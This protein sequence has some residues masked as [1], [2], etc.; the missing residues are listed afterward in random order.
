MLV[1]GK[2]NNVAQEYRDLLASVVM[3]CPNL[4]RLLGI[5]L[6][7]H[8]EYD[9]L[10]HALSTRKNLR[11]HAWIIG[12]NA[13]ATERS[14]KQSTD[15]LDNGQVFQF[16]NYH[17]SW[18]KLETMMLHSI[19]SRGILEHGLFLRMLNFLPSLQHLSVSGFDAN[20]F[21]D[22]T[23]LF[24]PPLVSL[25]LEGLQ[26]VTE[27]GLARYASRQEARGLKSLTLIDQN[28]SSL[29]VISKVLASL[30]VLERFCIVQATVAPS[31]PQGGMVFQPILA[32]ATVK[33]LHWDLPSPNP[34]HALN[35]LDNLS[36]ANSLKAVNTANSHL[37]QSIIHAGFPA[38]E[39]LR[40]PLDIDPL[41]A[42]QA[43]CRPAKGGLVMVP[44]DRYN[45][46]RSSHG[47]LPKRP[48]AMPAGNNLSSARIR[49]QTLVDKAH[50]DV[51]TGMKV[52]VTD[53]SG[54]L[55]FPTLP[56][57][58]GNS[59][60]EPETGS[61]SDIEDIHNI[62]GPLK[63]NTKIE[64]PQ[65][66][67]PSP[68]SLKIHEFT[69]PSCMGRVYNAGISQ[70]VPKPPRFA[71]HPDT[72]CS[73]VDGGLMSWKHILAANQTSSFLQPSAPLLNHTN[74][75][76]TNSNHNSNNSST[77]IGRV[78]TNS[79]MG[80]DMASSP[81]T[82]SSSRFS[83]MWGGS[84]SSASTSNSSMR[85]GGGPR[86][87]TSPTKH[88][89]SSSNGGEQ[90][91]WV[92]DTCHGAWNQGH[93]LGKDWWSHLERE[94]MPGS[95]FANPSNMNCVTPGQLFG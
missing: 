91:F 95:K 68:P 45:L 15:L 63:G 23:L 52:L 92:K 19:D 60:P 41:G 47:S 43:V 69:I 25:R 33:Y 49:A 51:D 59:D 30:V 18:S 56:S 93:K 82:T 28:I 24:L 71:L 61:D 81:S 70:K 48:L 87:P 67:I 9:R 2:Q 64:K 32:S 76:G 38:L 66:P 90:P 46:P 73:D 72:S 6:P 55:I 86:T 1:T 4:E 78:N 53:H 14:T 10:T 21:T 42:L 65:L 39:N 75:N 29:L 36:I 34:A 54:D 88:M 12:E 80:D 17:T 22:R 94:R 77:A 58:P 5:T 83:S 16:L 44:A 3:V 11:E 20:D 27:N 7:Y 50:K 31:L 85:S 40:A 89:W 57:F 74:T 62:L 8:H 79:S 13:E 35:Q 37:A 26:G 84:A